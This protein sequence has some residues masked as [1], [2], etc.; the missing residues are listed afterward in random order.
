MKI[1]VLTVALNVAGTIED[2]LRSV[3]SQT[4]PDVEHVIVDGASTDDT[5]GVIERFPGYDP[6]VYSEP[7][8]GLYDAMN[9]GLDLVTGDVV[10]TLNADDMHF[11][12]H[13]LARVAKAFEDPDLDACWGDMQLMDFNDMY[14]LRRYWKSSPYKPGRFSRGWVPPHPAFYARAELYREMKF[15]LSYKVAADFEM[16]LRMI[17][18]HKA[19]TAYIPATLSRFRLGGVSNRSFGNVSQ[20]NREILRALKTHSVPISPLW[21]VTKFSE[22]LLQ[23]LRKPK[24]A[25]RGFAPQDPKNDG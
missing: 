25:A 13:V 6:K 8:D 15:D 22:K 16:L 14:K 2:T 24:P 19:K 5:L 10:G 3:G 23:F 21:P 11:D 18:I 9:K 7:D 4:H 1:S 17:E 20:G 12:E